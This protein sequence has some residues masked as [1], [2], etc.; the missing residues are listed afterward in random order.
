MAYFKNQKVWVTDN[1]EAWLNGIVIDIA[2]D[3]SIEVRVTN[4][5]F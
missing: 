3:K 2:A 1:D 4:R 5:Y